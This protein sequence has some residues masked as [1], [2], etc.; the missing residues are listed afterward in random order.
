M[1]KNENVNGFEIFYKE[2]GENNTKHI[3]FLHGLGSSSITWGD[4]PETLSDT[5]HTIAVDLIGFGRSDKPKADYTIPYFS[6]FIKD[7]LRQIGI[8]DNDKIAIVGHSLGGY[9]ALKYAIENKEQVD[10]LVL[11][12]SSGMLNKPTDLLEK[13]KEAALEK[14]FFV[15]LKLLNRVFEDM[16]ADTSRYTPS[17]TVAFMS[18]IGQKGA[19]TAFE[20]AYEYSTKVPLDLQRLK[21]INDIPCIILWGQDDKLIYSSDAEKFKDV[22]KDVKIKLVDNAGHSPHFEKPTITYS[23]INTFLIS[24]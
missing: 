15:R 24:P 1:D 5:F 18:I 4:I 10:K 11:I 20:S 13:Y 8:K 2:Y 21:P 23:I 19:E 6:K 9:I 22:L 12:D 16:L 14:D 17:K 7:F 3:L